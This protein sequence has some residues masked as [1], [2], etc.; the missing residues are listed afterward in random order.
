MDLTK[1]TQNKEPTVSSAKDAPRKAPATN[2]MCIKIRQDFADAKIGPVRDKAAN[3]ICIPVRQ[4]P[5]R[6]LLITPHM[7]MQ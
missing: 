2:T 4:S 5:Q 6:D 7:E 3:P 1:E